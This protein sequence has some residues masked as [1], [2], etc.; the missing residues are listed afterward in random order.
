MSKP[1]TPF[2]IRYDEGLKVGYKWYEEEGKTPLFAFG[3]GLSYSNYIY[4]GMQVHGGAGLSVSFAVQNAGKMD[5]KETAQ[6]YV[7]FPKSAGEPAKRLVAWEKAAIAMGETHKISFNIDPLYSSV[8]DVTTDK[9]KVVPG[10]YEVF[11]GTA[12]DTLPLH[13]L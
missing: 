3:H 13:A 12:S 7:Q 5:G 6:V 11:V 10:E 1:E 4:S 9:W 8:F 2:D